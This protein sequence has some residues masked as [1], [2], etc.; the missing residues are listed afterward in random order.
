MAQL[1]KTTAEQGAHDKAVDRLTWLIA[2][3]RDGDASAAS[4]RPEFVVGLRRRLMTEFRLLAA[5]QHTQRSAGCSMRT[6][7]ALD[8]VAVC[9]SRNGPDAAEN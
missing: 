5:D 3:L 7:N 4:A 1:S 8:R 6:S 2:M 9:A